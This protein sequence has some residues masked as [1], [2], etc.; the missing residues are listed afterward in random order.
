MGE[1]GSTTL[2]DFAAKQRSVLSITKHDNLD[3]VRGLFP[4]SP[5][6]DVNQIDAIDV[7]LTVAGSRVELNECSS[8]LAEFL[9]STAPE[10]K[11]N[12]AD[13]KLS[14]AR[15]GSSLWNFRVAWRAAR[16]ASAEASFELDEDEQRERA[17]LVE[18]SKASASNDVF[19]LGRLLGAEPAINVEVPCE[20]LPERVLRKPEFSSLL[21]VAV[22]AEAVEVSKYLLEFHGAKPTRETVNQALSTGNAELIRMMM[23]RVY[24]SGS[25]FRGDFLETSCEFHREAALGWLFRDASL[26]EREVFAC[27]ALENK[28]ADALV[29]AIRN[30][31]PP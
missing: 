10:Q 2:E 24:P 23:G 29:V 7:V 18:L 3:T 20:F 22:G 28:Q 14:N 8:S 16:G 12:S 27:F 25:V 5:T 11:L 21:D 30:G 9:I 13:A 6:S 1:G 15:P 4:S 26:F 17:R 31:L 19:G